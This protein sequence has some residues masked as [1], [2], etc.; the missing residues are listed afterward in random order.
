M[1]LHKFFSYS[2]FKILFRMSNE[3]EYVEINI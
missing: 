1:L 3:M 2:K